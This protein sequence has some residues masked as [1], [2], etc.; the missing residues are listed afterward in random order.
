MTYEEYEEKV[1]A[2]AQSL[3]G[4]NWSLRHPSHGSPT[5]ALLR[6]DARCHLAAIGIHPPKLDPPATLHPRVC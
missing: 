1:E 5:D 6:E 4:P 3:A 2:L